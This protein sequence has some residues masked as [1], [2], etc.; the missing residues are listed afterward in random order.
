MISLLSVK[1][2]AQ[3][4]IILADQ[5]NT[6]DPISKDI[7]NQSILLLNTVLNSVEFDSIISKQ[8]FVCSNRTNLMSLKLMTQILSITKMLRIK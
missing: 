6:T 5:I 3:K 1:S 4:T 7:I 2:I 8:S